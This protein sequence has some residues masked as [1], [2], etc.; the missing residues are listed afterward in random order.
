MLRWEDAALLAFEPQ[1]LGPQRTTYL[2]RDHLL[3]Q[4]HTH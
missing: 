4:K 1:K 3:D 2:S